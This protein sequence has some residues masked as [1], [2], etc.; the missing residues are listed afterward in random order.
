MKRQRPAT[1]VPELHELIVGLLTGRNFD[2]DE[3]T[4]T[5]TGK[6]TTPSC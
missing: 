1:Y 4:I 5:G 2:D 6:G 3:E